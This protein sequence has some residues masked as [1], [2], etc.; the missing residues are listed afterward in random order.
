MLAQKEVRM[1]KT[2]E[3]LALF[4]RQLDCLI[5]D[6]R[7][8]QLKLYANDLVYEFPFANDRPRR[9]EG[10]AAFLAVM[11]PLWAQAREHGFK[12]TA[13]TRQEFHATDEAGLFVARFVLDVSAGDKTVSLEFVQFLRI[14]DRLIVAAQEYFSPQIRAEISS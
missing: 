5:R 8:E 2:D 1:T 12:V 7:T 4:R 10:K 11:S 6:D 14:R 9:I 13:I 3:A